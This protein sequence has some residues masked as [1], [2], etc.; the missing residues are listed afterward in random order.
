[1]SRAGV[2]SSR[3]LSYEVVQLDALILLQSPRRHPEFLQGSNGRHVGPVN[4]G[5]DLSCAG[6]HGQVKKSLRHLVAIALIPGVL[7]D[8]IR[9]FE[10][11]IGI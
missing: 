3:I 9:E 1:M 7:T 4:V 10:I 8:V 6:F 2:S 5:N 11:S